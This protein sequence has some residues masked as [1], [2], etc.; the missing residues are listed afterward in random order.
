[1]TKAKVLKGVKM[2][3]QGDVLIQ[4]VEGLE[5]SGTQIKDDKRTV[6]AYGEVT[7]HAHAF[8][9]VDSDVKL[10]ERPNDQNVI[11]RMLK[12]GDKGGTLRH[13]EHSHIGFEPNT[14][15]KVIQQKEYNRFLIR[16]VAD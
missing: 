1:M 14:T 13:E 16:N 2:I 7:G 12:V 9:D 10:L 11:E 4:R 8:S 5:A 6:L 15:Y 3:R